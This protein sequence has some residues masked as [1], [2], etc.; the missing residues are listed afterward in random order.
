MY[1]QF[2]M[3]TLHEAVETFSVMARKLTRSLATHSHG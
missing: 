2:S 3:K 1:N